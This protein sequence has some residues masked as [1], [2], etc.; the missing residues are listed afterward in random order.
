MTMVCAHL[1]PRRRI[2]VR[3]L[4]TSCSRIG[5]RGAY[6]KAMT[7]FSHSTGL[8]LTR[9]LRASCP[10]NG[11]A[12]FSGN[13]EV[14][15]RRVPRSAVLSERPDGQHLE[16]AR[17]ATFQRAPHF[18][19][20]EPHRRRSS[21]VICHVVKPELFEDDCLELQEGIYCVSPE[22]LMLQISQGASFVTALKRCFELCGCYS[23][24]H[25]KSP[26]QPT[27]CVAP[28]TSPD[29]VLKFLERRKGARGVR[30]ALRAASYTLPNSASPM[31]TVLV[32]MLILPPRLGGYGLPR[33]LLNY[34]IAVRGNAASKSGNSLFLDLYWPDHKL[35]LEY[36]SDDH[37]FSNVESAYHDGNRRMVLKRKGIETLAITKGQVQSLDML[38]NAAL[39]IASTL[40]KRLHLDKEGYRE[41]RLQLHA[42]LMPFLYG[43]DLV[44]L[45]SYFP[46]R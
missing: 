20:I 22:E 1:L 2:P 43:G 13:I 40:G 26:T 28:V 41:R 27:T 24:P 16:L 12:R 35:A 10:A 34:K 42:E 30:N 17:Q 18:Q 29:Q 37:H 15:I 21:N 38:D 14:R 46:E 31:E 45:G 5:E 33:P 36:D 3:D 11:P 25:I 9:M 44:P 39:A 32:I 8:A 23:Q 7:I 6:D 19:T 4:T